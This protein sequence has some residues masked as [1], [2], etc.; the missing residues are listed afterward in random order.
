M[1]EIGY[2]AKG[3]DVFYHYPSGRVEFVCRVGGGHDAEKVAEMM[4]QY[5]EP[6]E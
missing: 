4:N 1:L 3:D 5:C 6:E 2:K